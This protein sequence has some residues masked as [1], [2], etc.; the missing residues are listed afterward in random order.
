L[1]LKGV[2]L[3]FDLGHF[4]SERIPQWSEQTTDLACA[5][6]V[7]EFSSPH[8]GNALY[9][10]TTSVGPFAQA[11]QR[12]GLQPLVFFACQLNVAEAE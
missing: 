10:G 5:M 7:S 1:V 8:G 2:T 9:Q 4:A 3:C 6:L 12:I 11:Q